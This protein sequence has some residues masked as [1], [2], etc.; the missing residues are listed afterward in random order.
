MIQ[1]QLVGFGL[2]SLFYYTVGVSNYTIIIVIVLILKLI[3]IVVNGWHCQILSPSFSDKHVLLITIINSVLCF[4]P[5]WTD[6]AWPTKLLLLLSLGGQVKLYNWKLSNWNLPALSN[7]KLPA[8]SNWKLPALSNWKLPAKATE[9][10]CSKQLN[11]NY[12]L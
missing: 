9:A 5:G 11:V 4:V 6:S 12:L 2:L 10:A 7:W 8:L 1:I 3:L